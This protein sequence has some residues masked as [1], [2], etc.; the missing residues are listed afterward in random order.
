MVLPSLRL[1]VRRFALEDTTQFVEL[2]LTMQA[3]PTTPGVT[4]NGSEFTTRYLTTA[5]LCTRWGVSHMFVFR[6]RREGVLK[7]SKIGPKHTRFLLAD[8]LEFEQ[9][10]A[11]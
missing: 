9:S 3:K 6:R 5:E 11:V 2:W 7:F 8:V 4:T 1:R 10:A